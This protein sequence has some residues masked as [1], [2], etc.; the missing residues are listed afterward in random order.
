MLRFETHR[1]IKAPPE[2]V[3]PI[4][5]DVARLTDGSFGI[6]RIDGDIGADQ[7]FTLYAD[8][9]GGRGFKLR[10]IAFETP[11]RMVWEGG[12][13]LGLFRGVRTF[14][15]TPANGGTDFSMD[16]VFSGLMAGLI[17]RTMPDL[18]ESFE[19]FAAALARHAE[20]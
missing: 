3:W 12:M 19:Q 2:T 14:S 20:G 18:T 5:T 9:A 6:T 17:G 13:P 16:E 10:V 15:L 11:H 1:H 8:I 7:R 4:L